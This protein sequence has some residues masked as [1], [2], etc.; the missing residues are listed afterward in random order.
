VVSSDEGAIPEVVVDG[1]T[2]YIVNPRD[3]AQLT[4]RVLRLVH[5]RELRLRMGAAGRKRYEGHYSIEAY[6][7]NLAR[8]LDFFHGLVQKT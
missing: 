4:D 6:Q 2:G 3:I 8:A 7:K 5:D 1:V